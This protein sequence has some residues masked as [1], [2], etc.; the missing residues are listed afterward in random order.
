MARIR[1]CFSDSKVQEHPESPFPGPVRLEV[2]TISDLENR[3]K[4]TGDTWLLIRDFFV[5]DS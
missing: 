5:Y 1:Q 4:Y 2:H 3:D